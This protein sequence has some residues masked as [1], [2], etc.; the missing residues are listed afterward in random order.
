M[1]SCNLLQVIDVVDCTGSG[2]VD[3]SKV[4]GQCFG[5]WDFQQQQSS[6][7]ALDMRLSG[8]AHA[9]L[10]CTRNASGQLVATLQVVRADEDGCIT[11]LN[12]NKLCLNPAWTNPS[13]DWEGVCCKGICRRL[14]CAWTCFLWEQQTS[15]RAAIPCHSGRGVAGGRQGGLRAVPWGPQEP[16]AG[17]LVFSAGVV[18]AVHTVATL[19]ARHAARGLGLPCLLCA[20]AC[21]F[22]WPP[23]CLEHQRKQRQ[24][25]VECCCC[26]FGLFFMHL[27]LAATPSLRCACPQ[28]E[29][30]K[31]WAEKQRVAVA[32]AVAA[33]ARFAQE[34]PP[35]A[36]LS[37]QV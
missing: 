19:T 6:G 12:G 9:R 7:L 15:E 30:K 34:H 17:A 32:Q 29:R 28:K 10:Y 8:L 20:L 1:P 27:T 24:S 22:R 36:A 35:G 18:A 3:T 13:G 14:L 4:G 31:R 11:G 33:Q 5:V 23:C 26:S 25:G 37:E 2:D 16:A 21:A